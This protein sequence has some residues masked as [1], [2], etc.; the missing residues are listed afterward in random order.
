MWRRY[1]VDNYNNNHWDELWINVLLFGM[2]LV[3]VEMC[4]ASEKLLSVLNLTCVTATV[5]PVTSDPG[6]V[7]CRS[8]QSFKLWLWPI[9]IQQWFKTKMSCILVVYCCGYFKYVQMSINRIKAANHFNWV[10]LR[11]F[12]YCFMTLEWRWM[13]ATTNAWYNVQSMQQQ[14]VSC[15]S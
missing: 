6:S 11:T 5:Q 2:C 8:G 10:P 12:K 3:E 13:K 1:T 9:K 7:S 15:V 4:S 14:T